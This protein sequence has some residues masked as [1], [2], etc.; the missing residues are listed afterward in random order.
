M[1][2]EDMDT[3]RKWAFLS[4]MEREMSEIPVNAPHENLKR[5]AAQ[6]FRGVVHFRADVYNEVLKGDC[7]ATTFAP[8][9]AW[10]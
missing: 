1:R 2:K 8:H 9:E 10:P 4:E 5:P 7:R 3:G 6:F